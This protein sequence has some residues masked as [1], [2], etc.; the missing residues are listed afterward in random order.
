MLN[1]SESSSRQQIT[2]SW[3]VSGCSGLF[4]FGL[5]IA[6]SMVCLIALGWATEQLHRGGFL[7]G[8]EELLDSLLPLMGAYLAGV[9]GRFITENRSG[10]SAMTG[11][12]IFLAAQ[13]AFSFLLFSHALGAF[14]VMGALLPFSL[15]AT[16][17]SLFLGI[18]AAGLLGLVSSRRV[19]MTD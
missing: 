18:P 9:F 8:Q 10:F 2:A 17:L 1:P 7:L 5:L 3:L 4:A 6:L 15:P 11:V 12:V 14:A 16:H 13:A 19:L